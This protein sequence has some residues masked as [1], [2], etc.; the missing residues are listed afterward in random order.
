ML[1]T[2]WMLSHS[3]SFLPLYSGSFSPGQSATPSIAIRITAAEPIHRLRF[4]LFISYSHSVRPRHYRQ[5]LLDGVGCF[6]SDA[7]I[8]IS[9]GIRNDGECG[10][11]LRAKVS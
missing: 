8:R 1:G 10:G 11:C 2:V 4:A 3:L 9:H 6:A 5:D 7:H